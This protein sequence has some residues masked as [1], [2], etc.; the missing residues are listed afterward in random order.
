MV[1]IRIGQSER[2]LNEADVSWINQQINRRRGDNLP[3]CVRVT[4]VTDDLNMVLTTPT[5]A[6]SS[7]G[8]RAPKPKEQE[9][10]ELWAKRGLNE[11]SFTGGDVVAFFRQLGRYL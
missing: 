6:G 2:P 8:G 11:A 3:V 4:V 5:C 10:F 9:V 1:T 7:G